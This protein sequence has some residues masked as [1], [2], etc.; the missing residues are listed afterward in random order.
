MYS[1][2][3]W[4][5]TFLSINKYWAPLRQGFCANLNLY[6]YEIRQSEPYQCSAAF[7]SP[8]TNANLTPI[9]HWKGL[10]IHGLIGIFIIA[11]F[12]IYSLQIYTDPFIQ[13]H[14]R[15]SKA[16]KLGQFNFIPLK[17]TLGPIISVCFPF[18]ALLSCLLLFCI[19]D[20]LLWRDGWPCLSQFSFK[21]T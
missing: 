21:V 15:M 7:C 6:W 5:L 20:K 9:W 8:Y 14:C 19:Q 12:G 18:L 3:T 13:I 16:S 10:Q 4:G 2:S 11:L 17:T 1:T